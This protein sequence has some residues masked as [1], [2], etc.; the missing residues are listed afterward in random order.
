MVTLEQGTLM[1]ITNGIA[2]AGG[3]C[4]K[5]YDLHVNCMYINISWMAV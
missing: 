4:M 5:I 2:T 1:Q 3:M